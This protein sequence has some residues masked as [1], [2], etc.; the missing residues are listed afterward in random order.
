MENNEI[1]KDV[2]GWEG[3]YEISSEGRIRSVSRTVNTKKENGS[4]IE[5][6]KILKPWKTPKGYLQIGLVKNNCE[7]RYSLH[8][9]VA[10]AFHPN[11]ENKPQ[12]NHKNGIKTDCRAIN[13]EWTTAKE[14]IRH[15]IESGLSNKRQKLTNEQILEI[16]NRPRK[17]GDMNKMAIEFNT[18][19]SNIS[20]IISGRSRKN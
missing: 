8:R 18:H 7:K 14:N 11:P 15:S 20:A 12:V 9:L 19:A 5:I 13:L 10:I 6:G 1:W 4:R 16:R 17:Y 3:W 2:V